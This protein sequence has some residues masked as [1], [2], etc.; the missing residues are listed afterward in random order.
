MKKPR[1]LDEQAPA[2]QGTQ[3]VAPHSQRALAHRDLP[4]GCA[5]SRHCARQYLLI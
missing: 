1:S 4:L 3:V 2:P 5:P